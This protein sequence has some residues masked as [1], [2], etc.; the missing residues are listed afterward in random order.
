MLHCPHQ[1]RPTFEAIDHVH[2]APAD[3]GRK[4]RDTEAS[5]HPLHIYIRDA[6]ES[7]HLLKH[8]GREFSLDQLQRLLSKDGYGAQAKNLRELGTALK[9]AGVVFDHRQGHSWAWPLRS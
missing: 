8:L 5:K 1:P 4:T 9:V 6:V 3:D 2:P 7:S